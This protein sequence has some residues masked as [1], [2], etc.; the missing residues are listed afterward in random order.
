MLQAAIAAVHAAAPSYGE[1]DWPRLLQL[2]GGR[3]AR[4]PAGRS[5]ATPAVAIN[6]A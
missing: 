6:R 1:T 4:L 3:K 5:G 2:Y